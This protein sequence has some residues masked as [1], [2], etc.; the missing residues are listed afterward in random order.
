MDERLRKAK[1]ILK[2]STGF[3]RLAEWRM[4][5]VGRRAAEL[6]RRREELTAFMAAEDS[7]EGLFA[8]AMMRRFDQIERHRVRLGLEIAAETDRRLDARGQLRRAQTLVDH[9]GRDQR[10]RDERTLLEEMIEAF[11]QIGT[12][13]PGK[14]E[15][16]S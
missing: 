9:L 4:A 14:F 1:R 3:D 12:Q 10:G 11:A 16:S 8:E 13:G 6:N 15:G 7:F 2:A 5:D